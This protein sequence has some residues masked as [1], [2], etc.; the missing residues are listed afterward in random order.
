MLFN[1]LGDLYWAYSISFRTIPNDRF[2]RDCII[3]FDKFMYSLLYT[4]N[5][6]ILIKQDYY[7]GKLLSVRYIN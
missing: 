4:G 5:K 2:V 6:L 1:N 7:R 3:G